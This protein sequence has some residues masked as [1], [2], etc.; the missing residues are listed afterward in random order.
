[1]SG[2]GDFDSP[3]DLPGW[4]QGEVEQVI[5]AAVA[6]DVDGMASRVERLG[7]EGGARVMFAACVTWARAAAVMAG[8]YPVPGGSIVAVRARPGVVVDEQDPELFAA[9]FY[10]AVANQHLD[11]A[12]D[13]FV[14]T[15]ANRPDALGHHQECVVALLALVAVNGQQRLARRRGRWN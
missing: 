7:N 3:E 9:R 2:P 13:L 10:T 12:H 6:D 8:Q 15:Y 11:Q 5:L 1:V 14:A 4:V